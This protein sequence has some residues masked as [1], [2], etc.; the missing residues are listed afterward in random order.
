MAKGSLKKSIRS[1]LPEAAKPAFDA[2]AAASEE[3]APATMPESGLKAAGIGAEP[4]KKP[5]GYMRPKK[6]ATQTI[7]EILTDIEK[8]GGVVIPE[9]VMLVLRAYRALEA[10]NRAQRGVIQD[11]GKRIAEL[12]GTKKKCSKQN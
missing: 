8:K 9:M 1:F 4:A 3:E 12:K 5:R 11:L 7:D 2:G 6:P 10:T